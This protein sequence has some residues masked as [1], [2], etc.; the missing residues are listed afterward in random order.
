MH[1]TYTLKKSLNLISSEA[2]VLCYLAKLPRMND[3]PLLISYGIWPCDTTAIGGLKFS[4]RSSGCG[5]SWENAVLTTIGEVVERYCPV[6]YDKKSFIK[7]SFNN[8]PN[9]AIHP[10][11]IALF[12]PKQ[13]ENIKFPFVPFTEDVEVHWTSC[14]SLLSGEEIWFPASLIYM[15]Y[16]EKEKWIGL[17]TSTGLA[18]HTDIYKAILNGLYEVIER[19]CFVIMWMNEIVLNKIIIDEEIQQFLDNNF[20]PHYE[21]HFFDIS[22]DLNVPTVF[23]M[24]FG[25]ADYGRFVAVGSAARGT[26]GEALQKAIMEIGQ[27]ISYFRYML[28]EQTKWYPTDFNELTDFEKHSTFY[29]KRQDLWHIFDK[30]REAE[31]TRKIEFDKVRTNTETAEI[32]QIL[33][34]LAAKGYEVLLKYLATPDIRS[35]GFHSVKI[36]VPQL[37]E[38][39]GSYHFYFC[40]GNRLYKIP[41]QFGLPAKSYEDLNKYP[42]PFP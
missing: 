19:D 40:G 9:K 13:Y 38:M 15:P 29:L 33:K 4:G 16:V 21:F 34:T 28:G 30:W 1:P 24:C 35:V 8:F 39:S 6:F 5:Y 14:K 37:L 17:T 3:D 23:G 18:A 26:F 25:E 36:I 10:D 22:F 7:S 41:E 31:A 11:N 42:H 2:G 27:A 12:H 20:P 32:R